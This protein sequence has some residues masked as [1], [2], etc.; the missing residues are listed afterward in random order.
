[1]SQHSSSR[2]PSAALPHVWSA[3]PNDLQQCAIRL[4]TQLAFAHFRQHTL[5][6]TQEIQHDHA[7]QQ[8]QD[9]PRPS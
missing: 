5:S 4:L 1:M 2:E 9:S 7:T 3:L 8:L 6:S